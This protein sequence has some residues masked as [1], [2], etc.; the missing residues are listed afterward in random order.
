MYILVSVMDHR[1]NIIDAPCC[2]CPN[3]IHSA[4]LF[5]LG[6]FMLLPN[7]MQH[8][9]YFMVCCYFPMYVLLLNATKTG[10][11]KVN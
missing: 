1:L 5:K 4:T 2:A 11:Q 9:C 6:A 7:V 3:V 8:H 10:N